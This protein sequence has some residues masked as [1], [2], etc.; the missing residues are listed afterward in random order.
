MSSVVRSVAL[1][2]GRTLTASVTAGGLVLAALALAAPARTPSSRGPVT[3]SAPVTEAAYVVT[4][5]AWRGHPG[6]TLKRYTVRRGDTATRIAVR[7]H[8]WTDEL[9]AINHKTPSSIWYVGERVTVPIV[10]AHARRARQ[11]ARAKARHHR[12]KQAHVSAYHPTHAQ[13]RDEVRRVARQHGVPPTL[14]LAIAWQESGWQQQ[15]RSS[16]GAVG[17]MQVMPATG[18]WLSTLVGRRLHL[19]QLHDNVLA[20]VLLFS[21]LRQDHGVRRS[22]AGYY[23]GIG[24]V[25]KHGLYRSTRRYV[26]SVTVHWRLLNRGWR[27]LG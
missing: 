2:A 13:V 20:G 4:A 14:A 12:A 8:A 16:V 19:R 5:R 27:P 17:T 11:H 24:S 10:T 15:V 3:V 18:R 23:Q 7:F 25:Q 21:V 9:L 22:L 1:R 26:R 6:R